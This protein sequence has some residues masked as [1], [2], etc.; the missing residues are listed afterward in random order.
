MLYKISFITNTYY[1]SVVHGWFIVRHIFS[2]CWCTWSSFRSPRMLFSSWQLNLCPFLTRVLHPQSV[3]YHIKYFWQ[4]KEFF[5]LYWSLNNR[6]TFNPSS[7]GTLFNNTCC[8]VLEESSWMY[9]INKKLVVYEHG[10]TLMTRIVI[11]SKNRT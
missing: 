1:L 8:I 3:N 5:E 4:K 6:Q 11:K 2:G 9:Q 10:T 7:I